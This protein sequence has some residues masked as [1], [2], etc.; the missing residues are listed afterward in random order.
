MLLESGGGSV[1]TE[2][3]VKGDAYL[4]LNGTTSMQPAF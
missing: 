3:I 1:A 2:L 4:S